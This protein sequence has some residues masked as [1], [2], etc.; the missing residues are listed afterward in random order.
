MLALKRILYTTDFSPSADRALDYAYDFARRSGAQ[1]HLFHAVS[2]PEPDPRARESGF[3]GATELRRYRA[4]VARAAVE[5]LLVDHATEGLD[6]QRELREGYTARTTILDYAREIDADLI[7]QGS[8]GRTGMER[9]RLGSVAEQVVR[10]APCPVLTVRGGLEDEADV[11][12]AAL[13]E[14][15]VPVDFSPHTRPALVLARALA[16]LYA[17]PL[18]LF[19]SLEIPSQPTFYPPISDW[20]QEERLLELARRE[21]AELAE[22]HLGAGPAVETSVAIGR[23]SLETVR[24]AKQNG[25]GLV[26][27][28]THGDRGLKRFLLGSTAERLIRTAPC[29]VLTLG[30]GVR[31]PVDEELKAAEAWS[32]HNGEEAPARP[33]GDRW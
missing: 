20:S 22:R 29:P 25:A 30:P 23:A 2:L 17:V 27:I 18:H 11:S 10:H 8:Q 4:E 9:L 14:I 19:H 7:V 3:P 28:S 6:V 33:G 1:L 13:G 21:L 16:E 24:T 26:V 12:P 31:L 5:D 15:L 32:D